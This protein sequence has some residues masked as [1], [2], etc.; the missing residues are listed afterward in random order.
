MKTK[1]YITPLIVLFLDLPEKLNSRTWRKK[2]SS[3]YTREE[4]KMRKIG[5]E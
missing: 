3:D 5:E 2:L 1:N 4:F